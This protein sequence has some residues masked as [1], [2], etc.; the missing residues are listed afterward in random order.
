VYAQLIYHSMMEQ[1]AY[2]AICLNTGT[3]TWSNACT[4]L[5]DNSSILYQE[6]VSHVHLRDH[7]GE[8][9][10]AKPVKMAQPT[11]NNLTLA[12]AATHLSTHRAQTKFQ[13]LRQWIQASLI[14]QRQQ[15]FQYTQLHLRN[16]YSMKLSQKFF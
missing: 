1:N 14:L 9:T 3:T 7:C 13:C 8:I 10:L 16:D 6:P 4:A 11:T 2:N 12:I 15:K 5:K